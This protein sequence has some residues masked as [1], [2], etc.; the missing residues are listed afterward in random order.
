MHLP[1]GRN[2]VIKLLALAALFALLGAA[3]VVAEV[4]PKA[5]MVTTRFTV[6]Q[7][8]RRMTTCTGQDGS[9][10]ELRQTFSGTST[11][12][13]P[14]MDP[15]LTG[16]LVIRSKLLRSATTGVGTFSGTAYVISS[17]THTV[18]VIGRL[19]GATDGSLGAGG[20]YEALVTGPNVVPPPN[21]DTRG[22][23][24]GNF[25][26]SFADPSVTVLNGVF[27]GVGNPQR[28]AVVIQGACEHDV[29]DTQEEVE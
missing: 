28:A 18:T 10:E 11:A 19:L 17:Q 3:S 7:T 29:D 8:S 23:L 21:P 20:L 25:D 12:E 27:G 1:S 9:Y 14:L 6:T 4:P 26:I 5:T 22:K 2:R 16:T 15:Y 24:V 13:I